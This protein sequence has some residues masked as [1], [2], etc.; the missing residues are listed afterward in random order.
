MQEELISRHH[1]LD[2][3]ALEKEWG[4]QPCFLDRYNDNSR[5]LFYK[6]P[7]SSLRDS[8]PAP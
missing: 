2:D 8:P 7:F 5:R 1:Q 4:M 3:V 6:D